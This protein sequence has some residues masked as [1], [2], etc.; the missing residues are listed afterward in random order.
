MVP[1][2]TRLDRVGGLVE[3]R[4]HSGLTAGAHKTP[5][6]A[7]FHVRMINIAYLRA[8]LFG[9]RTK[10]ILI[11]LGLAVPI[12]LT[13]VIGAYSSGLSKAQ[14][15][16]LKP[17][18]GLGTDMTVTKTFTPGQRPAGQGPPRIGL[19]GS[20]AGQSF[21]RNVFTTGANAAFADTSVTKVSS[22]TGVSEAVG[23]LTVDNVNVS[24]TIPAAG[25]SSGGPP[26][27]G[28][29]GT[30]SA[31]QNGNVDFNVRTITGIDPSSNLGPISSDQLQKGTYLTDDD[32]TQALVS[33]SY[34]KSKSLGVGDTLTLKKTK[35]TIVGIVSNPLAGSSSDIYVKLDQLQSIAGLKNKVNQIYVR[36]DSQA[37]V[38]AVSSAIT[39]TVS[40]T[41]VTTNA[42]LADQ[43]SGSLL[44]ANKLV[45]KWEC[46]SCWRCC[47]PVS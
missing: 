43:V 38:A 32:S 28:S 26:Q 30:G 6:P 8:E 46:S 5:S 9:R 23:G 14:D 40:N 33:A 20:Q 37:D 22:V 29:S 7:L 15:A 12:A 44:D 1:S 31:P 11:A 34:A 35:F 3:R 4:I 13:I 42:S 41:T 45:K 39:K 24:G 27:F 19:N 36:A 18:V 25:S 47:S 21:S 2:L 16:V 10:T 17:L